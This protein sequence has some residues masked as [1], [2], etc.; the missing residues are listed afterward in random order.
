MHC[1]GTTSIERMCSEEH[2]TPQSHAANNELQYL[3]MGSL[4][5]HVLQNL[6]NQI[7]WMIVHG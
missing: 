7:F 1:H 5:H 2:I 4:K 3:R 6:Q